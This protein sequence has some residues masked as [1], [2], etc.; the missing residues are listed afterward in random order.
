MIFSLLLQP[1]PPL[2]PP[3][4]QLLLSVSPMEQIFGIFTGEL[5]C[6]RSDG[7]VVCALLHQWSFGVHPLNVVVCP[8]SKYEHKVCN[9]V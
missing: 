3:T 9:L 6:D 5:L 7:R 4:H 1:P 8:Q 2:L